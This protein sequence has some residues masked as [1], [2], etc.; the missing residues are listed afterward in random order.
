MEFKDYYKIMGVSEG[1]TAE[2]IKRAYRKLARKYHPD[3]SKEKDAEA[4]FKEL[5]EAY[6]VLKDPEKKAKYDALRQQGFRS[7]EGFN[8]PP[9]WQQQ[10]AHAEQMGPEDLGGFSDFFSSIFGQQARP[11]GWRQAGSRHASLRGEDVHYILDVTP[12]DSYQGAT[13]RIEI[14]I[15]E[16]T[17]EG[18]LL[19]KTRTI[20]VK[21][22]KGVINGQQ[23]RLKGQG[24]PGY[25]N[26]P[27]G[28]LY[29]EVRLSDKAPFHIENRDVMVYLP[30]SPWEAALGAKIKVPTLGGPLE[31]K[32]PPD[33][34]TGQKLR[35]K[36]RG[37]PGQPAGDQYIVLQ[38][39][40]PPVTNETARDLYQQMAEKVS[41]NPREKWGI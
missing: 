9:N 8:V 5:G 2:E 19:Q 33:S 7:G 18:R 1:A 32:I 6:E 10:G 39:L 21:I 20:D 14:P 26:G 24:G 23:I 30:V 4:K 37:L 15:V 27:A 12:E 35:L 40:T 17:E 13:R 29:L 25:R 16:R 22:P 34:Q 31:V 28:D 41:F 36:G 3:V 38:V 11:S